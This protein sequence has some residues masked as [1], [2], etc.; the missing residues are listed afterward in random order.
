VADDC[1]DILLFFQSTNEILEFDIRD[2]TQCD[3]GSSRFPN[4]SYHLKRGLKVEDCDEISSVLG[5]MTLSIDATLHLRQQGPANAPIGY[6]TG[7]FQLFLGTDELFIAGSI[8]GTN[9]VWTDVYPPP[10]PEPPPADRLC[11]RSHRGEGTLIGQRFDS[12]LANVPSEFIASYTSHVVDAGILSQIECGD[13]GL[14][15]NLFDSW[16][17]TFAGMLAVPCGLLR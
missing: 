14:L 13:A 2:C 17:A 6:Q 15:R 7:E 4:L 1:R 5:P 10:P 12:K 3:C 8:Q 9:G 11:G 16:N